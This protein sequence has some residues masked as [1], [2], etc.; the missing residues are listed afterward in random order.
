MMICRIRIPDGFTP[1]FLRMKTA[2]PVETTIPLHCKGNHK[3]FPYNIFILNYS[4]HN[5]LRAEPRIVTV[6]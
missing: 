2:V 6:F 1:Q 5:S 3:F 4:R